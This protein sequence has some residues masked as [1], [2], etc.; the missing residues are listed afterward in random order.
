MGLRSLRLSHRVLLVPVLLM[1]AMASIVGFTHS[2]LTDQG[3]SSVVINLAGR[4]RMLNQRFAKETLMEQDGGP[5]RSLATLQ[6]LEISAER[7][8][9]GGEVPLGKE[10]FAKVPGIEDPKIREAFDSQVEYIAKYR[11]MLGGGSPA[12]NEPETSLDLREFEAVVKE[13]HGIANGAVL[14]LQKSS[15]AALSRLGSRGLAI[16]GLVIVLG[17]FLTWMLIGEILGPVHEARRVLAVMAKGKLVDR[18][19]ES[20][21]RD[22]GA[23]AT[24]LNSFQDQLAKDLG[25]VASTA[26]RIDSDAGKLH[27]ASQQL[28]AATTEQSTTLESITSSL[29]SVA[30]LS[31]ENA[32]R[33]Q[34]ATDVANATTSEAAEGN[35]ITDEMV[36]AMTSIKEAS[37]AVSDIITVIDGIAF[38]TNLLALNA[39][40]EAARAGE[41][42]K[43]FAVVAE[44][45]RNLA[46][47]SA[48]AARSST[49]LIDESTRRAAAGDAL[50]NQVAQTL[51]SIADR[52]KEVNG[53]L[54]EI[55][56]SSNL[57]DERT[58]EVFHNVGSLNEVTKDNSNNSAS[59]ATTAEVTAENAESLG[60]IV[61]RFELPEGLVQLEEAP[62]ASTAF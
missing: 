38:Q 11:E 20:F 47:R 3:S 62:G 49:E 15:S 41:A 27:L 4:Q 2:T 59:L 8:R 28:A 5:A 52:T 6:L 17:L 29:E 33:A 31:S 54:C 53:L 44:E 46:Q 45:V 39:A 42:G 58:K 43:G 25:G 24:S 14:Q 57:Q 30:G 23:L 18:A 55:S 12:A 40:V 10:K 36:A 13:F 26:S 9:D 19:D 7:L 34:R 60:S 21:G 48:E 51:H 61:A 32:E 56:E 50:A 22:M 37:T 16:G 1:L 35:R